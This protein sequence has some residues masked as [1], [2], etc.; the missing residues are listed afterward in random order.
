MSSIG[1]Q[2]WIRPKSDGLERFMRLLN[3]SLESSKDRLF[4]SDHWA[5]ASSLTVSLM[6]EVKAMRKP[7]AVAISALSMSMGAKRRRWLVSFLFN[8]SVL[9]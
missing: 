4:E 5:G 8:N 6:A 1:L 3:F 2:R 7:P 9:C